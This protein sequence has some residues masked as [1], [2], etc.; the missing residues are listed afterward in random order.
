[1]AGFIAK[2]YV[3]SRRDQIRLRLAGDHLRPHERRLGVL[4]SPHHRQMYMTPSRRDDRAV[5][6]VPKIAGAALV[7]SAIAIVYLGILPTRFLDLRPASI[8]SIF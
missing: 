1:M 4:L 8:S 5:P 7:V 3:F 6:A 2:W